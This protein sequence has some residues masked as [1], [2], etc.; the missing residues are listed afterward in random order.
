MSEGR[1][2]VGLSEKGEGIKQKQANKNMDTENSKMIFRR[3]G[4]K[5]KEGI[6]NIN[7]DGKRLGVVNTQCNTQVMYY[8]IVCLKHII[9]LTNVTPI[10]S[11]KIC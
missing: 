9:L 1:G 10:N 7:G 8:R 5:V 2:V 6:G 4:R 11:I 3:E